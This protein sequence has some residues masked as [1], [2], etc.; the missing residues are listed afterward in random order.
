MFTV[1]RTLGRGG[2]CPGDKLRTTWIEGRA[3]QPMHYSEH[4]AQTSAEDGPGGHV[5]FFAFCSC[6]WRGPDRPD[7][8]P[9]DGD[10]WGH[11]DDDL[12]WGCPQ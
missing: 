5:T 9:A 1:R 3:D 12:N 4:E 8:I 10:R 7:E 11:L 2:S 6:G